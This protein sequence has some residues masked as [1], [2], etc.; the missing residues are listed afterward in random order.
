LDGRFALLVGLGPVSIYR[1]VIHRA[2]RAKRIGIF[3]MEVV[4]VPPRLK[5]LRVLP[6]DSLPP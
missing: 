2:H 1:Y 5:P 4:G 3:L 6:L